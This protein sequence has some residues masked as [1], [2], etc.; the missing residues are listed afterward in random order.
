M[1]SLSIIDGLTDEL[2]HRA[3]AGEHLTPADLIDLQTR[4]RNITTYIRGW[5]DKTKDVDKNSRKRTIKG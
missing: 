4:S 3:R 1:E 2:A 5:A